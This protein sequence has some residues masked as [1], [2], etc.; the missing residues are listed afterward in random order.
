[1][2][3]PPDDHQAR[4]PLRTA[5]ENN[6]SVSGGQAQRLNAS[7]GLRWGGDSE[8]RRPA[9]WTENPAA[10][11]P[12]QP[13]RA[14]G[15]G[16]GGGVLGVLPS[17][18]TTEQ[19]PEVDGFSPRLAGAASLSDRPEQHQ[20]QPRAEAVGVMDVGDQYAGGAMRGGE[21]KR[22]A[23]GSSS[24]EVELEMWK[25]GLQIGSKLDVK[26]TVEKWCEAEVTAVDREAGKVFISYTYWSPKWDDWFSIDSPCLAPAGTRT[27]QPGGPLRVG[28]RVEALDELGQEYALG[29]RLPTPAGMTWWLEADVV[30]EGEDGSGRVHFKGYGD[31][32]DTW[33]SPHANRVRQYGPHRVAPKG[34]NRSAARQASLAPGQQHVRQ[35]AQLSSRYEH[36]ARALRSHGLRVVPVEGDGNCLFRSVSHQIYGDDRHHRLVRA[37]CMD[38]ME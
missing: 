31:K 18:T 5:A 29:P 37:R 3:A 32:F 11:A 23:S 6:S 15:A 25:L 17:G 14:S 28:H 27:Y 20:H 10:P 34:A 1:M 30:E 36:Y 7:G 2:V 22:A 12:R 9:G 4:T 38:Y 21:S 8:N 33:V 35:I 26:D 19:G 13:G 16:A 24:G